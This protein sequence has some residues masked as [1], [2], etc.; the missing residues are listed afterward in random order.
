MRLGLTYGR[1]PLRRLPEWFAGH[2]SQRA[3]SLLTS[4]S[5]ARESPAPRRLSKPPD[6]GGASSSSMRRLRLVDRRSARSSAPSSACIRTARAVPDRHGIADDLIADLTAEGSLNRRISMTGTI[7]F[8]ADEV[9]LARWIETQVE[10]AGIQVLVGAVMTASS[11]RAAACRPSSWRPASAPSASRR[12]AS[13]TP[14]AMPV[15]RMRPVS[16]CE[17]DAPVYGS[18]N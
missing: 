3:P 7:T 15:R 4:A 1:C 11:S 12:T 14:R 6:S 18:L 13:W 16:V 10:A 5:S 8:R 17:P 2:E 9:R